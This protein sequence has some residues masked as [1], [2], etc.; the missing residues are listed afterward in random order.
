MATILGKIV[1]AIGIH[2]EEVVLQAIPKYIH[3]G[4]DKKRYK[5]L[6]YDVYRI[7]RCKRCNKEYWRYKLKS[8]LKELQA[9]TF[10]DNYFRNN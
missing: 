4:K 10:I 8:N 1:C 5:S 7:I 6:R 3:T 2:N 9:K